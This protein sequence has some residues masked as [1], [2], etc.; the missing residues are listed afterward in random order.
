MAGLWPRSS[1]RLGG[2]RSLE[3]SRVPLPS[4]PTGTHPM[5]S[6]RMAIN[7]DLMGITYVSDH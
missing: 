3:G 2:F 6:D 7:P 1:G 5:T 4:A